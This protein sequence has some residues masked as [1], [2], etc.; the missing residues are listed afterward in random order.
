MFLS[1]IP[2]NHIYS[3]CLFGL[4]VKSN[5]VSMLIFSFLFSNS[6]IHIV[7]KDKVFGILEAQRKRWVGYIHRWFRTFL[8]N[9]ILAAAVNTSPLTWHVQKERGTFLPEL[10]YLLLEHYSF[11]FFIFFSYDPQPFGDGC[12]CI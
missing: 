12:M 4:N 9:F 5:M 1:E 8:H 7:H 3:D 6:C 2:L 11:T 10:F